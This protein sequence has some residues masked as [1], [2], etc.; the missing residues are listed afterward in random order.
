MLGVVSG[1]GQGQGITTLTVHLCFK[2]LKHKYTG[3]GKYSGK[4][5]TTLNVYL[6]IRNEIRSRLNNVDYVFVYYE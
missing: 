3:Q 4:A 1:Q 2:L 5:Y 6:C